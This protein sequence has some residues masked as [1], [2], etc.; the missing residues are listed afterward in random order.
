MQ[1]ET[2]RLG[3]LK[4][5][6]LLGRPDPLNILEQYSS[7]IRVAFKNPGRLRNLNFDQVI[8]DNAFRHWE[9][10]KVSSMILLHGTTALTKTDY[11]WLSPAV[12][13]LVDRYRDQHKP[14]FF[15]FCHDRAFMEPDTPVQVVLSSLI[16]QVLVANPSV[17][18]D[19]SLYQ[20]LC[21]KF[22]DSEQHAS[23]AQTALDVL[24]SLL[25]RLP[26]A[27]L[28]LDRVDR[29]KGNMRSFMNLLV[30][31]IQNCRAT[32]KILLVASSNRQTHLEVKMTADLL[33]TV[34]EDLGSQKFCRL[35]LDQR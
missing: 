29:I 17:L 14:V 25:D 1:L 27:Y 18:H 2:E 5:K 11:S 31:L 26:Q 16:Y 8:D 19:V 10:A 12:F 9:S 35:R 30:E 34:E 4:R 3:T 28:L 7:M 20:E 32:I 6:L 15:H 23:L 21:L 33:E 24:K 13:R 22:S